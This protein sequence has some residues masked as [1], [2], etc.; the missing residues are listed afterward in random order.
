MKPLKK[1]GIQGSVVGGGRIIR[2]D[3]SLTMSVFGYSKTFGRSPGCNE[4]SAEILRA[5]FPE[6]SVT[7]SDE[8]Y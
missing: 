3:K 6:Y 2:D 1:Q 4:A 7:W 5:E 8:G